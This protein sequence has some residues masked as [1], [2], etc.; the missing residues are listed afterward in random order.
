MFWSIII[1]EL[2]MKRVINKQKHFALDLQSVFA[3]LRLLGI[4]FASSGSLQR[5]ILRAFL[6]RV[7]C[8]EPATTHDLLGGGRSLDSELPISAQSPQKNTFGAFL[9]LICFT[10]HFCFAKELVLAPSIRNHEKSPPNGGLLSWL[11]FTVLNL[12]QQAA[13]PRRPAPYRNQGSH[14]LHTEEYIAVR[15]ALC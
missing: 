3:L 4:C 14:L 11:R 15:H 1:I 13:H 7:A 8:I 5:K 10:N 2:Y 6:C 12:M 9:L